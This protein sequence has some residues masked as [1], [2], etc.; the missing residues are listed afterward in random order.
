MIRPLV[1]AICATLLL[2]ISGCSSTLKTY[3]D[4]INIVF[5]QTDTS[6][7][8]EETRQSQIDIAKVEYGERPAAIVALAYIENGYR[9]W[10]SSDQVMFHTRNDILARTTG[11]ESELQFVGGAQ[12]TIPLERQ[13]QT[14]SYFVDVAELAYSHPVRSQWEFKGQS[15]LEVWGQS[16][17]ANVYEEHV[18]FD[19]VR[20]YWE[21][22]LSWTN[23][24]L[25]D[26]K[27]N[28]VLYSWQKLSP[29]QDPI[30]FT[31]LSRAARI[32]DGK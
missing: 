18:Q 22:G 3:V 12:R 15:T 27:S 28:L 5:N 32:I 23:R 8:L 21:T 9:K 17:T 2:A 4:S 7:S 30:A 10:V 26:P 31:Y 29:T 24:Y 13:T 16:I 1:P 19:S 11:L 25:V 14:D 6:R 20:P